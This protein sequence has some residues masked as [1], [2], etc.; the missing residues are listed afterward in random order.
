MSVPVRVFISYSHEPAAQRPRVE[1]LAAAL[2]D[3]GIGVVIDHDYDTT[4][5]HWPRWCMEQT[6]KGVTDFILCICTDEYSRRIVGDVPADVGKGVYWEGSL[7]IAELYDDKNNMRLIPV[8]LDG[9]PA[10]SI[11]RFLAGW[12][13]CPIRAFTPDDAG[14]AL[15]LGIVRRTAPLCRAALNDLDYQSRVEVSCPPDVACGH[16]P[17]HGPRNGFI[18]RHAELAALDAAWADTGRTRLLTLIA[19]GGTGKTALVLHWLAGLRD[20]G[21]DEAQRVFGWSFYSQ[22]TAEDRQ[23]SEEPFLRAALEFFGVQL[24]ENASA[25]EKGEKLAAAIARSR[26]LLILDGLEP[27][28]AA[29]GGSLRAA[30]VATLLQALVRNARVDQP[31]LCV[32]TSRQPVIE[33]AADLRDAAHPLRPVQTIPLDNLSPADGALLLY[34]LGVQRAGQGAIAEA[35]AAQVKLTRFRGHPSSLSHW[36]KPR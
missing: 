20:A 29:Q 28:Q 26:T 7:F 19:P 32:L 23:A 3:H 11:P 21:W 31:C 24:P 33:F 18:G 12:T 10:A 4:C 34:R 30:G 27:L 35:G 14:F 2:K 8:L 13:Q 1:A 16:I 6:A 15:L 25:Y 22:G 9:E 36:R 17:A 5:T